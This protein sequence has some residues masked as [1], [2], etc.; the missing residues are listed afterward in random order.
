[1][2]V[3]KELLQTYF[4]M[5][6]DSAANGLIAVEKFKQSQKCCPYRLIF[7]DMS[8][9]VMD[10]REASRKIL[11][12]IDEAKQREEANIEDP[13]SCNGIRPANSSET[14]IVA[15]TA[16]NTKEERESCKEI[17]IAFQAKP[18]SVQDIKEILTSVFGSEMPVIKD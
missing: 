11:Q 3:L 7:M 18:A 17:G 9:P 14:K 4:Q 1:V 16:N 13:P 6:S 5:E 15:H 10:G 2:T 12:L 8:M